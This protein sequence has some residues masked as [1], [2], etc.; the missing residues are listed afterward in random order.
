MNYDQLLLLPHIVLFIT[1]ISIWI[2]D[3]KKVLKTLLA[4]SLLSGMYVGSYD[5]LASLVVVV[6]SLVCFYL[7]KVHNTKLKVLFHLMFIAIS[8]ALALH[9]VPGFLNYLVFDNYKFSENSMPFTMYLNL[10]KPYIG[11]FGLIYFSIYRSKSFREFSDAV[12]IALKYFIYLALIIFP[13]GLL[14][15]YVA[16]DIKFSTKI[17]VWAFNNLFFV[18][19]MEEV[20]FRGY[21]QLALEKLFQKLSYA[22]L[23][24]LGISSG[25]FGIAHFAGGVS[26]VL[27]ATLAGMFYGYAFYKSGKIESSILLH[28]LL[29]LTHIIF[30][31]YPALLSS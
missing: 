30:F 6:F 4:L 22:W 8:L 7:P 29:N 26:Y 19:V 18:C 12:K 25:L 28:F 15:S 27:L 9:K 11:I 2:T 13:I 23:I 20:F 24:A 5:W 17:W 14:S 21:L 10:D 16:I 31:S 3:S 1:T